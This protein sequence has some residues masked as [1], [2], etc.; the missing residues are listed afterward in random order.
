MRELSKKRSYGKCTIWLAFLAD[1][2]GSSGGMR[3]LLESSSPNALVDML[4]QLS[5]CRNEE[6]SQARTRHSLITIVH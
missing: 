6:T 5:E 3:K 1:C 2:A 4:M